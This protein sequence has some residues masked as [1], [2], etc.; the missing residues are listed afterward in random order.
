M[1]IFQ[2][3]LHLYPPE[4]QTVFAPEM[5]GLLK[6][7]ACEQR[8]RG[9]RIYLHFILKES[10][11][12]LR[13]AVAEWIAKS[14]QQDYLPDRHPSNQTEQP[15]P[16]FTEIVE[17]EMVVQSTLRLMEHAIAHH[18]FEKARFYSC[19]ERKARE[20]LRLLQQK[21]DIVE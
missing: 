20:Q 17:A 4:H 14:T 2:L 11:G 9:R 3:L 15:I 1:L 7:T 6:E 16:L 10:F 5:L 18:Q 21:Y 8:Q 12:L 13:G 19:A